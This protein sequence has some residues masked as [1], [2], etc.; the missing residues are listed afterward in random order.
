MLKTVV[1]LNI[2]METIIKKKI[3]QNFLRKFKSLF[4]MEIFLLSHLVKKSVECILVE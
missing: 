1:L 2:F 4:E 3:P